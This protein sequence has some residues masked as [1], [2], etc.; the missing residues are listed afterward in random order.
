MYVVSLCILRLKRGV[1]GI[2]SILLFMDSS[3]CVLVLR[4]IRL[5]AM[6]L[7]MI[8]CP[9]VIPMPTTGYMTLFRFWLSSI[10]LRNDL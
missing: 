8:I 9:G 7:Y 3:R 2:Q 6:M 10:V 4:G 1:G 5:S